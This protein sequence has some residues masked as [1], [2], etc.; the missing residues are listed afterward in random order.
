MSRTLD[1]KKWYISNFQT[2]EN[3]LN[4]ESLKPIHRVRKEA[5][6]NFSNLNFPTTHDEDWRFTN[7]TP[8]LKHNFLPAKKV[9]LKQKQI[10]NFIFKNIS[11]N[12]LVFVNGHFAP[13]LSKIK[14]L[15]D[16]IK[17]GNIADEIKNGSAIIEEHLNKY[18]NYKT[19]IFTALSTAF[20]QDGAFIHV[21]DNK[22][23]DEP[24]NI[25]FITAAGEEKILS[26]PRNLFVAGKNSQVTIIER[27]A[28]LDN[29][30]YFTNVVSEIVTGENSS[31]NHIKIQE[32][33]LKA[34]HVSRTEVDQEKNSNFV[35]YSISL[36]G[37]IS[38][39]DLN[40]KF[41]DE[42]GECSL[43]GLYLLTGNQL[44][45]THSLID[46]AKPHCT[47]HEHYKGILDD[48]SRGVF[49]GKVIVRKDAQKTNAFQEN[50]N[51]ILSDGALVNTK[52]QL[53]IFAD[54]VKC[55][56]GATVGQLDQDS[57]FYLRSRGIGEE[58][59]RDILIHAFAS[60]VIKSIKVE[61]VKNYLEEI[62][63]GRFNKKNN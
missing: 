50:N 29:G 36:G 4:G 59:A 19:Q 46:H 41:N 56:H 9:N 1:I 37:E 26:Q 62:L 49:N 44:Y 13:G 24:I 16:G 51:I 55:S 8:L 54:D 47:S 43:N 38:R 58:K 61:Q 42:G 21:H 57:L 31:I 2:F 11:N 28:S 32:E 3:S 45:D 63:E 35:S 12:L 18:A 39:Y 27:Y 53:E 40:S 25:L 34:F 14:S 7:I 23:V 52:P 15:P 22:I 6:A 17:V 10:K 5:I 30:I 33:G 60:D 20:T 48:T